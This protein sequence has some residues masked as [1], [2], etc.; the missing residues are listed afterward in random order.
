MSKAASSVCNRIRLHGCW[1]PAGSLA[2]NITLAGGR[3]R[4][5]VF[6]ECFRV[7]GALQR[8]DPTRN[9]GI[10]AFL[11]GV[12]RNIARRCE[13]RSR[14]RLPTQSDMLCTIE[15]KETSVSEQL[16]RRWVVELIRCAWWKQHELALASGEAAHQRM[17]LLSLRFVCDLPVREIA[18]SWNVEAAELHRELRKTKEEFLSSLSDIFRERKNYAEIVLV[19]HSLEC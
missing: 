3:R 14:K 2:G 10:E 4:Q 16:D 1:V 9:G 13:H 6:A 12:T 17:Q 5:D 7:G 15:T 18:R 19:C 8:F 11:F